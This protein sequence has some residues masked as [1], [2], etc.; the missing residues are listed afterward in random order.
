[1]A[2]SAGTNVELTAELFLVDTGIVPLHIAG[3]SSGKVSPDDPYVRR[4]HQILWGARAGHTPTI[5]PSP[6]ADVRE[7]KIF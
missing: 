4:D 1:M 6:P 5:A 3:G 7:C 2:S